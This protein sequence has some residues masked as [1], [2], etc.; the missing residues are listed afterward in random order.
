MKPST[1]LKR[2]KKLV[3]RGWCKGALARDADGKRVHPF[4]KSARHWCAEGALQRAAEDDCRGRGVALCYLDR[5]AGGCDVGWFNDRQ[6][7]R[8]PVL[9]AFDR[10]VELAIKEGN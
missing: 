3:E 8:R 10:A 2:A 6:R 4:D 9:A 7:T 5:A 1:I